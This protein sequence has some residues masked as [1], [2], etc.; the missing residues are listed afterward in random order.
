MAGPFSPTR[1][2]YRSGFRFS[3]TSSSGGGRIGGSGSVGGGSEAASSTERL[4]SPSLDASSQQPLSSA[5]GRP[6][7]TPSAAEEEAAD[8]ERAMRMSI[9]SEDRRRQSI[10]EQQNGRGVHSDTTPARSRSAAESESKTQDD[11]SSPVLRSHS[12]AGEAETNSESSQGSGIAAVPPIPVTGSVGRMGKSL[13]EFDAI[14]DPQGAWGG[15]P[16]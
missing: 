6:S 14:L 11:T 1:R 3:S 7:R 10:D 15:R 13:K 12:N 2:E 5:G 9:E 8:L 4:Q 16:S